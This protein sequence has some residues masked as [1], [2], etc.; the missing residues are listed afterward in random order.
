MNLANTIPGLQNLKQMK[1]CW[2][3]KHPRNGL[4]LL[5]LLEKRKNNRYKF[6]KYVCYDVRN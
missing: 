2:E 4:Q 6:S 5:G 3:G 1:C